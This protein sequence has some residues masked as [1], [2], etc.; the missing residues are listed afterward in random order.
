MSDL[1]VAMFAAETGAHLLSAPRNSRFDAFR[2]RFDEA[3]VPAPA[4]G[5]GRPVGRPRR[6]SLSRRGCAR[7][8]TRRSGCSS[9]AVARSTCSTRRA[10]RS[11]GRGRARSTAPKLRRCS[12][13]SSLARAS[14]SSRGSRAASTVRPTEA[15]SAPGSR[16]RCSAA[17][18]TATIPRAHASLAAEIAAV[19]ADRVRVR[20]RRRAGAV[21]LPGAEQNRRRPRRCDGGGRGPGAQRC[22]DHRRLRARGGPRGAGRPGRDHESP[23]GRIERAAPRSVRHLRPRLPTCSR[24]WASSSPPSTP[25]DPPAGLSAA[26]RGRPCARRRRCGPVRRDRASHGARGVGRVGRTR[27]AGAARPRRP[28]LTACT[29]G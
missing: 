13:V 5:A 28:R 15:L 10:W 19:G 24:C 1:A 21:A 2:Q 12:G 4:V 16:W 7:F 8:T 18:S 27:R 26:T 6:P 9:A 3:G 14:S 22:A 29:G 20:T 11:S 23:L 17:A 25:P